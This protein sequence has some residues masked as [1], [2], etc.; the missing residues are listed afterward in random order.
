M[1]EK[2]KNWLWFHYPNLALGLTADIHNRNP[3][4]DYGRLIESLCSVPDITVVHLSNLM[5]PQLSQQKVVSIRHDVDSDIHTAMKMSEIERKAGIGASYY[6]LPSAPY[7][8]IRSRGEFL[9][10]SLLGSY[11]KRIQKNGGEIGIHIDCLGD[12]LKYNLEPA[13]SLAD[14]LSWLRSLGATVIGCASHASY[15]VYGAA[16]FEVI[17]GYAIENREQFTDRN[18]KSVKL[19]TEKMGDHGLQYEANYLNECYF[20]K[21]PTHK[22]A[23]GLDGMM[24]V[25]VRAYDYQ[26]SIYGYNEWCVIDHRD[27]RKTGA[28]NLRIVQTDQMISELKHLS[29]PV[30]TVIDIHPIYYGK[31][32]G[33]AILNFI[34]GL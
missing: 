29:E 12:S 2:L 9:R 13:K 27:L 16:N 34:R 7:Y 3:F 20:G 24:E 22:Y 6:F 8:R 4:H 14:E 15:Y 32:Y 19:G 33:R 26:Y 17:E 18:G 5:K 25:M 31:T 28:Y 23:V 30:R 11:I 21:V 1:R 10:S